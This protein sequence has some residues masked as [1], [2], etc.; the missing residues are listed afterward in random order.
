[1]SPEEVKEKYAEK[2]N[3][4]AREWGISE[5]DYLDYLI[6]R[7]GSRASPIDEVEMPEKIAELQ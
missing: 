3:E 1:M 2:I 6:M 7:Y 4:N 5:D